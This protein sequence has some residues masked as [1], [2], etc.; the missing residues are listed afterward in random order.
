MYSRESQDIYVG[1]FRSR[2]VNFFA[3]HRLI[4]T[5]VLSSM[6]AFFTRVKNVEDEV[7][8]KKRSRRKGRKLVKTTTTAPVGGCF[9]DVDGFRFY[10][11]EV[12]A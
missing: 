8:K 4:L 10:V 6:Y 7:D 5:S 1:L 3:H 11:Y 12:Y 2:L 9:D